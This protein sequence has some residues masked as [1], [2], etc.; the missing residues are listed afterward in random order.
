MKIKIQNLKI[1]G[2][3]GAKE[4]V[5]LPLNGKSILLYGDNGTGK[6]SI[7]DS[8]EWF[9]TDKV[10]HLSGS[11]I[12]LKDAIRNATINDID[13][14]EITISY[15]NTNLDC[16][17]ELANKRGKLA[18]ELLNGTDE[19]KKYLNDSENE[20]LL[21]RYQYLT[22]FIDNTKGEKLKYLSDII[23]FGEVTKKKEV[24]QKSHNFVKSEIKAQNFDAQISYQKQI[25]I[26]KLGAS[27]SQEQQLF[28]IINVKIKPLN[29]GIEIKSNND[30]D[31]L[32]DHIK[33]S[34]NNNLHLELKFLEDTKNALLILKGEAE[35]INTEYEKYYTEFEI[36]A[37]D[38]DAIMKTYLAELLNVGKT[39]LSKKYHKENSCP[40]CLQDKDINELQ[41]EI[42]KRLT[43]IEESSKKKLSY[44]KA[45]QSV[46]SITNERI[47]R[48]EFILAN[49]EI[50]KEANKEIKEALTLL[51]NKI[52][53]YQKAS[54]IKVTSGDKLIKTE[55]LKLLDIDFIIQGKIGERILKIQ[56]FQK[57]DN[58][59]V[60]FSNISASKEAFL[61]IQ[62]FNKQK[63]ILE[64]QR[65]SLEIIY[66][67]FVKKQKEG[68]ENFINTFSDRINEFYQYMNPGE[69]F[70]EIKIV[71][72]GEDDELNGITIEY[73]YNGKW[74]SPPQKYFS[75]SHLN[76]FG[77]SFFLASVEAFNN[78]NKFIVLDDVISSFDSNHRKRFAELIFEKFSEYQIILLT[79]EKEW[80]TNIVSPLARKKGWLTNEIK[81]NEVKGTHIKEKPSDLKESILFQIAEGR[82]ENIGNPMRKYLEHC[83]KEIALNLEAKLSFKFNDSN[84]HRM[85][86]ELL[87]A[88]RSAIK[89]SSK[90]LKDEYPLLNRIESSALFGNAL[91][92]D[93]PIN[94]STGDIKSFWAD[95]IELEKL[96]IC[97]EITCR[98]P[99]VS[100]LNYDTVNHKIRCGCD[101]TKYDW[102]R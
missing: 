83:L 32:L 14:S 27:I 55:E 16:T 70:Q 18:S 99:K 2:I 69:P 12:D 59:T 22:N 40:L 53:E 20:N 8:I 49:T 90:E 44:D 94:A 54:V 79:H 60:L 93:N 81:W 91:S 38:V 87:M 63:N 84:E 34:V 31:I 72:I 77:I 101:A 25:L 6:S 45:K 4:T 95:I 85:P 102:K 74:V 56:E 33:K 73:K 82:I 23:G 52:S 71:T 75:E 35:F 78:V 50:N 100:L 41:K 42:Q 19:F 10:S 58:A 48:L 11:E 80:F 24:L 46:V 89:D 97:Q 92:H 47:K 67:E 61:K 13:N 7:S 36:I 62:N 39:V 15:N 86:Y 68:L 9:Y 17:K 28:D 76:C 98:R 88:I 5:E 26:D 1:K 29:S 64:K 30:I 66:N 43:E 57:K 37:N 51:Q 96:F 3:R 65:K 21:L